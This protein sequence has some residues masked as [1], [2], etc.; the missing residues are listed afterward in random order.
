MKNKIDFEELKNPKKEIYEYLWKNCDLDFEVA[1]KGVTDPSYE[2]AFSDKT[3]IDFVGDK[4]A[5]SFDINKNK[6][7]F[8][9]KFQM[10]CSGTGDELKKITTLHSS[11]LCAL[12]FFFNVDNKKLVIP[13]LS[14]YEFTESYFEFQNK[15]IRSPSNIDVVLLGKNIKTG[16][17][18]ILFLESKFSEYITGTG[19]K[20]V[21][22]SYFKSGSPSFPIYDFIANNN[23]F[24]FN[25]EKGFCDSEKYNEGL[26]QMISHYYGI[27]N[28][29]EGDFFKKNENVYKNI[30]EY[31]ADEIILGEI[32]FDN[33]ATSSDL[34]KKLNKYKDGYSELAKIINEQYDNDET[35]PENIEFKVLEKSLSYS[36]LE[37][38][39]SDFPKIKKFY[40]G[41]K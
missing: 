8:A 16:K 14:E 4:I 24:N 9:K 38:Y 39:I 25:K 30:R 35:K 33:F 3:L 41:N 22:Q 27:R 1:K 18:V 37:K 40:F 12:L 20:K 32:L 15:V 7:T 10:A 2:I 19:I 34:E 36:K 6:E 28:F 5:L 21:S 13:S 31:G 17:K 26:K 23:I 29:M 11:S